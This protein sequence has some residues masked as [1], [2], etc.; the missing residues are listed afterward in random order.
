MQSRDRRPSHS[1][2]P[3]EGTTGPVRL[4]NQQPGSLFVPFERRNRADSGAPAQS[5]PGIPLPAGA[6]RTPPAVAANGTPPRAAAPGGALG[7]GAAPHGPAPNGPSAQARQA[8]APLPRRTP[9]Q[10]RMAPAAT[11]RRPPARLPPPPAILPP[12]PEEPPEAQRAQG[13]SPAEAAPEPGPE[14]TPAAGPEATPAARR[15]V[16][17]AA[18]ARIPPS[19][20][21]RGA[22]RPPEPSWGRVLATTVRLWTGRRLANPGWRAGLVLVLAA[23]VFVAAAIPLVLSRG[24]VSAGQHRATQGRSRPSPGAGGLAAA[25]AARHHAA[26]WVAQQVSTGAIVSCDPAMCGALEAAHVPSGR[27]I[28]LGPGQSDPLGSEVLVATEALRNQFGPRLTSVYAPIVLASFGSGAA[29]IQIR[30]IAPDGSG[31][32]L[33][34]LAADVAAR[35]SSGAQMLHNPQIHM[36]PA[37]RGQIAAGYVDPRLLG[38]LV[39]LSGQYPVEILG[40][41]GSPGSTVSVVAPLRSADIT[42]ASPD[43]GQQ[44]ASAQALRSFLSAQ[45]P[46]YRP[47]AVTI[48]RLGSRTVLRVEYPAPTPLGLLG[49]HG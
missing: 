17:A 34:Q 11:P 10:S 39:T 30:V 23:I 28:V 31:V 46:P 13:K 29:Q 16:P 37:A 12:P 9:G 35:K 5:G 2:S 48:V 26:V 38:M 8:A 45:R 43:G 25:A 1:V 21:Q 41:G 24:S 33:S 32:Y 42:G 18:F 3:P 44:P 36:S 15:G 40:F 27:L 4:G 7:N 47:S 49:S 14:A 19:P 6:Q 22:S 20:A